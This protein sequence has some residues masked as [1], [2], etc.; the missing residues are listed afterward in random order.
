MYFPAGGA[1]VEFDAAPCEMTFARLGLYGDKFYMIIV[2]GE[3]LDL[4]EVERKKLRE[5]TNPT[6]PHMYVK[7]DASYEEFINVFPANHIHG[8]PGDHIRSLVY[9][10]EIAGIKP[11]VLGKSGRKVLPPLWELLK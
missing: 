8:I 9:F 2:K 1:S 5:Q 6:W 4:P 11:I 7:L 10:C 3:S